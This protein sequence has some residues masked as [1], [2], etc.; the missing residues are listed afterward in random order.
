MPEGLRAS[1]SPGSRPFSIT[2]RPRPR[3]PTVTSR[4]WKRPRSRR[5]T[6]RLPS[7]SKS[8]PRGTAMTS[9]MR[10]GR[11]GRAASGGSYVAS[12]LP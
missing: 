7:F 9:F 4:G 1:C 12:A 2:T 6:M 3:R 8:A 11:K 5:Y 10:V